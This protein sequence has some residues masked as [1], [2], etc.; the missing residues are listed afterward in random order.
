MLIKKIKKINVS[1][2]LNKKK[3]KKGLDQQTWK[4]LMGD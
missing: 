2:K 1:T 3:I 4:N